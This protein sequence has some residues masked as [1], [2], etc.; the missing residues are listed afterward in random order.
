MRN[1]SS[2]I[3]WV[4]RRNPEINDL[5]VGFCDRS[6]QPITVLEFRWSLSMPRIQGEVDKSLRA[7]AIALSPYPTYHSPTLTLKQRLKTNVAAY[8]QRSLKPH[9][10]RQNTEQTQYAQ[11]NPKSDHSH[12]LWHVANVKR[13]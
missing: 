9:E 2:Y 3:D 8:V 13:E 10:D 5:D 12:H 7:S 11:Q 6:T 1:L 4:E